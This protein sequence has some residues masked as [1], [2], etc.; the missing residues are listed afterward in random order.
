LR[1]SCLLK[2]VIEWTIH[3]W[4]ELTVKRGRYEQLL[5][6]LKEKRGY[7]KLKEKALNRILWRTG[8]GR[9]DG[10]VVRQATECMNERPSFDKYDA[11]YF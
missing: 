8:C 11:Q 6:N 3:E 7:W 2:H 9:S 4:T 10:P 1:R 5:D